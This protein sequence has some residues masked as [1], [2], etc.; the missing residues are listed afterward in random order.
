MINEGVKIREEGIVS[1]NSD[2]DVVYAHGFG[3]PAYRGGPM[4]YGKNLGSEKIF[5][6]IQYYRD[7]ND[8]KTLLPSENFEDILNSE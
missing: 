8:N 3:W 2:I 7:L 1:R 4:Y 5:K 6:K